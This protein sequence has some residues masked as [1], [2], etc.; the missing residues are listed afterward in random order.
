MHIKRFVVW[1]KNSTFV[2]LNCWLVCNWPLMRMYKWNVSIM[3][4]DRRTSV[5][6]VRFFLKVLALW[7]VLP[8]QADNSALIERLAEMGFEN[9]RCAEDEAEIVYTIENDAYSIQAVGIAK[10][11]EEIQASGLV[12][13]KKCTVIVTDNNVPLLALTYGGRAG[14]G[15]ESA[16]DWNVT[17]RD[18]SESWNK[19]KGEEKRNSSFLDVDFVV[20]PQLYCKN[21]ILN[22]IYQVLLEVSPAIEVKLW[23]GAKLTAQVVMPVYNDGYTG[24][25]KNVR[26]GYIT[27]QQQFRLP[28]NITGDVRAGLF[29]ER[30]YGGEV[31]LL[32]PLKNE[33]FGLAGK[34]GCVGHG[35][36]KNFNTFVYDNGSLWYWSFGPNY[37]WSRYNVMFS[38]RV[39]QYMLHEMGARI[40][41]MRHYKYCSIGF[42]AEKAQHAKVNGGF[43][44]YVA[45]PPYRYKR[46]GKVPKVTTGLST[47]VSYNGDNEQAYYRMPVSLAGDN[48]LKRN[49]FNPFFVKNNLTK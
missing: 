30:A 33:H 43:R 27:L 42:Y 18:F 11:I 9:V 37:Y 41:A 17:S 49:Q 32:F 31:N 1:R 24:E 19:V 4:N 29:D 46:H 39:E 23:T 3:A 44:I 34:L 45:I 5:F 47:G 40:D 26:P 15:T 28:W 6:S 48:P 12:G 35:Y 8:I 36:F 7:M 2:S 16:I 20:Y 10:A 22:Q 21:H 13:G 25:Y 14:H 38:L